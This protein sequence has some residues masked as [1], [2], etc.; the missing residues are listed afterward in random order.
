M[1]RGPGIRAG[2]ARSEV[3]AAAHDVLVL[4]GFS[5]L[6]MRRVADVLGVAPNTLYSHVR[7]RNDLA[8]G[9]MDL[10]LSRITIPPAGTTQ[11]RVELVMRALWNCLVARPG[12]AQHL[13][14]RTNWSAELARL[15]RDVGD[16]FRRASPAADLATDHVGALLSYTIGAAAMAGSM[17][18][19][20]ADRI[21]RE[22][23][24][25]FLDALRLEPAPGKFTV[26]EWPVIEDTIPGKASALRD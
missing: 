3:V 11:N 1:A 13:Q 20:S 15:R 21:F 7:D 23:L 6:T 26:R 10:E 16:L 18:I 14:Q 24:T 12:L 22:G 8:D 19:V 5:A 2:L 9:V 4:E 17:G 25:V